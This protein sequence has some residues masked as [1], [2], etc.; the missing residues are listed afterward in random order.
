MNTDLLAD[1]TH[2]LATLCEPSSDAAR[3]L[4]KLLGYSGTRTFPLSNLDDFLEAF[5]PDGELRTRRKAFLEEWRSIDLLFQLTDD[6]LSGEGILFTETHV[7]KGLMNSYLFFHVVL[8]GDSYP[9]SKLAQITRQINRL[10]H[11]PVMVLFS[12]GGTL[13]IAVINRRRSKVDASKDV[14]GKVTLIHDI[15]CAAPHRGHRDILAS[16]AVR[17]LVHPQRLPITN[18][19]TLHAAWEEIFNVELLNRTFYSK[20]QKWFFWA[21]QTISVPHDGIDNPDQR[22]RM[23][24]IR[25]LTRV[26]FCWFAREKRL[27]P[28]ELFIADTARKVLKDFDP[29]SLTDGTYY[30]AIL[31]NLFFPTL[32]VPLDQREFRKGRSYKG[33]NEHYMKHHLFRHRSAFKDPNDIR[34][35]FEEIPFL[36][37]GLFTC[38][39]YKDKKSGEIRIDGFSDVASK[40]PCIPNILFF[41]KEV[42]VDISAAT[43]N[44]NDTAV[45]IDGLFTILDAFKFT[46]TENTPVEEE[47]A[48]D[49]ELLGR[50]F[51][52]LLAEY[53]PETE[54]S[55]RK[56]T[57]S[58]YTPRSIVDYMVTESL[59][60]HLGSTLCRKLSAVTE[61]DTKEGLDILFSYTEREHAFSDDEKSVLV[62]AIYD[63]TILDPACGS[64]A[65]PM[66]MLQKLVYV[67]DKLDHGHEHWKTRILADTPAV[68]KEQTR[69]WL[70]S[71]SAD[72][73]W[74]LGLIQRSI[75]GIDIQPFAV[76][77][78]KLRCFVSLLVDFTV[79]PTA[80]NHGVPSLPNLD[81]KFV[82]AN[83]LIRPPSEIERDDDLLKL[84]D[85]FFKSLADLAEK[86]FFVRDPVEKQRLQGKI[87]DLIEDQIDIHRRRILAAHENTKKKLLEEDKRQIALW[88]SY[89][90]IFAFRN[91][92]VGFF[93]PRYFFPEVEDGFS[94]VIGNPPYVRA[95]EQ[96]E[97][98]QLQRR[99]ILADGGYE[100]LKE[101]WDLF[102]PFIE[103]SVK[104][105][106]PDGISSLI[107]SDAFCHAKYA[108]KCQDWLLAKSRVLRL[109]F[110][111]DLKI[112][113]AAVHNVIPFIQRTD[114]QDNVPERRLHKETFGNVT[115]LPSDKQS[116]LTYR[117]FFPED[118][119]GGSYPCTSVE[120]GDVCYISKG[121]VVHADERKAQGQF[122][123]EDVVADQSD[124]RH[125]KRF[126]EGK[127]LGMWLPTQHRWLEWGTKRAPHLFSRPTFPELHEVSEKILVQRSPGP[128]P[129]CCYDIVQLHFTESSVGFVPWH[130][131]AGVRNNS[132]KKVARYADEKPRPDLPQREQLEAISRRFSIKYLLVV[133]NSSTARDFLRANRR[134]NIHLY[135]DDWKKLPIPDVPPERQQP[136]VVLVDRILAAK[137]ADPAADISELEAELDRL[138]S[139]LYG[140]T[141]PESETLK[142]RQ[143]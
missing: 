98:N 3:A 5:D 120:L 87:E 88:E 132:L 126:V 24:T 44:P 26:I 125:P 61:A 62:D 33:V 109:D 81:F 124:A 16:L 35:L 107:V 92:H 115:L 41:G 19:D 85:P 104:L 111:G 40:Q 66:G 114:G 37:G 119:E 79:D 73:A 57:G 128:D 8:K 143:S 45:K 13:S 93:D 83:T 137:H 140:L 59:K 50:I 133:M 95:D 123:M 118:R 110:C 25:L 78:A 113:E 14:L 141:E 30:T 49:P 60:A 117:T 108:Q 20:I 52:N 53:N 131:L 84:E 69:K 63:A 135:P 134:S 76:Q 34:R 89:R 77:I 7:D 58:F 121:M 101:K 4:L 75:Y 64:G 67:L 105:L 15:R 82:A 27:I 112:F 55:A 1:I 74:K 10:F 91:A 54:K 138:V 47:I 127:H 56:Q 21:A 65:F 6:D 130:S 102:I 97:W 122:R 106:K 86:Y 99:A 12:Y 94:I 46:V 22:N 31:Q 29:L 96:S 129:K 39:D 43:G 51:E 48:L 38:L 36:N 100:T 9:R 32:S 28:P 23:A 68:I 142:G 139:A 90:N 18:F 42:P 11:V 17:N 2:A 80:E 71:A 72:F 103:R 136:L 70:D 116:N